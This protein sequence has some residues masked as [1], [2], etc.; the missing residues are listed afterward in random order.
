MV[1]VIPVGWVMVVEAVE[2]QP[3]LVV[4]VTVYVPGASPDA[5][6]AV[7]PEEAHE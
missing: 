6:A 4:T 5:V 2:I 3:L 1:R 7:P